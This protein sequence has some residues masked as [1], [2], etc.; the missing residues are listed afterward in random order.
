MPNTVESPVNGGLR[1]SHQI[2][3]SEVAMITTVSMEAVSKW[4]K[5]LIYCEWNNEKCRNV[6]C[7]NNRN[8]VFDASISFK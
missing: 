7:V 5:S 4:D 1:I 2:W 3:L 6:V 8:N